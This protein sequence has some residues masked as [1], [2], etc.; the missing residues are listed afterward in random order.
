MATID[1]HM[2]GLIGS[3]R[4]W[5][6]AGNFVAERYQAPGGSAAGHEGG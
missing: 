5:K 6:F 2:V 4:F 3:D 1:C